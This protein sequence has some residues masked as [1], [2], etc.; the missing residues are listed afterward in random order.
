MADSAARKVEE[1]L[2]AAALPEELDGCP[3]V[4]AEAPDEAFAQATRLIIFLVQRG[5]LRD[6]LL[7]RQATEL[8]ALL[9]DVSQ[10]ESRALAEDPV[11]DLLIY[12]LRES[13]CRVGAPAFH[14]II[15]GREIVLEV[16]VGTTLMSPRWVCS[17]RTRTGRFRISNTSRLTTLAGMQSE[18][19]RELVRG[20]D[21]VALV[22][23]GPAL[24][25]QEGPGNEYPD[26]PTLCVIVTDP[27]FSKL[28]G[29][30]RCAFLRGVHALLVV[31]LGRVHELRERKPL[32]K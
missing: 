30:L 27:C 24:R 20:R 23:V 3:A 18:E 6:R 31:G 13:S 17:V 7:P 15:Y 25:S 26:A 2:H 4:A 12:L 11:A 10:G 1:L 14:P 9:R 32:M 28:F 19:R 5:T 8:E 22:E 16:E 29:K 21:L